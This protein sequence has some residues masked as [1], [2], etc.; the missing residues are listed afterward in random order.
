VAGFFCRI[1]DLV[2]EM[3]R[4]AEIFELEGLDKFSGFDLPARQSAQARTSL[5][6]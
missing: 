5:V 4:G 3:E 6:D 1:S 2:D